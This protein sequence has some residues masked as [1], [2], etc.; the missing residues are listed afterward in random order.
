[1]DSEHRVILNVGGIRHETYNHVLKKIPATR[2][3]RLT[4]NLANYDP[5]LNEYFFDRHP[6][7]FSMILNYYRTGKLHYPTN[8]CGPLFEEELEFWGL[9]ANQV[10]PCCWMT[11]TS[12]RDTQETL[13]VIEN[14]DLDSD[15]PT[16]EE[17]AKKFGWEDDFFSGS[18]SRWQK[19]KPIV[20]A[21]FDEPC[22]TQETLQVIENLDLDSD[23]PTQEEIAKKF[24]WEDDFFSG[25]L[26][27][28][29]KLKPIVWAV[30]DEPW[31]SRYARLISFMSVFFII[32]N[33]IS[34][35]LKTHQ[36][37]RIPSITVSYDMQEKRTM[38]DNDFAG[39]IA[40]F[41]QFTVPHP[42]FFYVDF[43]CNIFFT[44][45]LLVRTIFAPSLRKFFRSPLTL[46]DLIAT[47]AFYLDW[48]TS[49]L[50]VH[51]AQADTIDFLSIVCILRLFKLTKHF[52]GLK[53]IIQ[54]FK[55]SAEELLLLV[56]FV[57][58]AIVTF[59]ALVYYAERIENNPN[60]Q[61]TSI[62]AG[63]WWS[64][65]TICTV[66]FGDMVPKTYPGMLVGSLCALMG[67]LTIALPVPAHEVKVPSVHKHS[68]Y[69]GKSDSMIPTDDENNE[70]KITPST[71]LV[72]P[73]THKISSASS[74]IA[75]FFHMGSHR[76]EPPSPILSSQNLGV[77]GTTA[78]T[79]LS[80]TTTTTTTNAPSTSLTATNLSV[81]TA[82]PTSHMMSYINV[83]T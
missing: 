64:L 48:I 4:Q 55:N 8:V 82:Q 59:A 5:I 63:L 7:V 49:D 70:T 73:Q 37:F 22:D 28:W 66:G 25:S 57:A 50:V 11:Y 54:T 67:V 78:S 39:A 46:I 44:I 68:K 74:H 72:Q 79:T 15:P 76:R 9:D 31:S 27:R 13:Q 43:A 1:M 53:I 35:V 3:S 52:A 41:K 42:Y 77:N 51:S 56:F 29:Q 30:F 19:L 47:G 62:P 16:Q 10:E 33:I 36:N 45:E 2:L 65:I 23:P 20:W 34:F 21:V 18:L 60:N 12:H 71:R 69:R 83:K 17:I 24:G 75:A 26:S 40:T 14:L 6:G 80:A 38:D 81:S 58:L 61:F 32:T